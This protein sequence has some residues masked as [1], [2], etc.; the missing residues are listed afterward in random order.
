[1]KNSNKWVNMQYLLGRNW[2]K[3][4]CH[5]RCRLLSIWLTFCSPCWQHSL[6][7]QYL[8]SQTRA[9]RGSG[10]KSSSYSTINV[11]GSQTRFEIDSMTGCEKFFYEVKQRKKNTVTGDPRKNWTRDAR[12]ASDTHDITSLRKQPSSFTS[13]P[14]GVSQEGRHSGRERRRTAVF[15][16]YDNTG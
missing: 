5:Q 2:S 15:A 14:S 11:S 3:I 9:G 10:G 16:G 8:R 7:S 4:L 12:M 1:V 6:R 13:G